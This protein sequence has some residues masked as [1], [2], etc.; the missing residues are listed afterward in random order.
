MN[1]IVLGGEKA[2][3]SDWAESVASE[4]HADFSL[5]RVLTYRHWQQNTPDIDIDYEATH[6][7]DFAADKHGEYA[8]FAKSAGT[9]VVFRA[10]Q[11]GLIEPARVIMVG[12]AINFAH[13]KDLPIDEW[14]QDYCVPTLFIQQTADPAIGFNELG[15]YLTDRNVSN[16]TLRE[17]PGDDHHYSDIRQLGELV[18]PYITYNGR[19]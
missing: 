7:H 10:V 9:W 3:N 16:A 8:I 6:L 17:I 15:S 12:T 19:A 4:L 18:R 13:E 5:P 14:V 11:L 2:R 1:L